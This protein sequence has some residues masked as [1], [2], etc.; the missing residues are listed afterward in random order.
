MAQR[1][2]KCCVYTSDVKNIVSNAL[3]TVLT[4][5]QRKNTC[6]TPLLVTPVALY[7]RNRITKMVF[8][9]FVHDTTYSFCETNERGREKF[10]WQIIVKR[11]RH[12]RY[13]F[14]DDALVN[15]LFWSRNFEGVPRKFELF[16]V[17]QFSTSVSFEPFD[18]CCALL[19]SEPNFVWRLIFLG[20]YA[21]SCK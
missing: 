21:E 12:V 1:P 10:V 15:Q 3:R 5:F 18:P 13:S 11:T 8:A 4:S 14:S 20:N 7:D 16:L 6:F 9:H 17:K 2:C 19:H